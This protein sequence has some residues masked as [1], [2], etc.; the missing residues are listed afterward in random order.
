MIFIYIYFQGLN[1]QNIYILFVFFI[2][3]ITEYIIILKNFTSYNLVVHDFKD[4]I[5]IFY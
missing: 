5:I 1:P 2:L 3:H 4:F